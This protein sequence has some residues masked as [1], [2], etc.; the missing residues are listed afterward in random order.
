MKHST[1]RKWLAAI[2]L[3][4]VPFALLAAPL[5]VIPLTVTG[6]TGTEA[7][8]DF[9]VLVRLSN[10]IEGF[11]YDDCKANGEDVTF[12]LEDGTVLSREIDT[13]NTEGESLIW[14]RLPVLERGARFQ[15]WYDDESITE[16]PAS[17]TDGSVWRPSGYIG[18][19]HMSELDARDSTGLGND[20]TLVGK[21]NVSA[22]AIVE[23][24]VGSAQ[25]FDGVSKIDCGTG[26][27]PDM[28]SGVSVEGWAR[29]SDFGDYRG[30]LGKT[31]CFA[32][33]F[34]K[35]KFGL[36]IPN[37]SEHNFSGKLANDQWS[38][39]V[40]TFVPVTKDGA[41]AYQDGVS[42][43]KMDSSFVKVPAKPSR[44]LLGANQWNNQNFKGELDELRIS[45]VIRSADWALGCYETMASP[46]FLAA[47]K[48]LVVEDRTLFVDAV[49]CWVGTT[50]PGYGYHFGLPA[51]TNVNCSAPACYTNEEG[52][53]IG[54]CTG[55]QLTKRDNTVLSSGE[56]NTYSYQQGDSFARLA[57]SFD[58]TCRMTAT[59][60]QGTVTDFDTWVPYGSTQTFT[61]VPDG[62][63]LVFRRWKGDV[64]PGHECENPLQLV[65]EGPV[66]LQADILDEN[67]CRWTGFGTNDL[68]ST[69]ENWETGVVPAPGA[70]I[71]LDW[72]GTDA[73]MTWDLDIPVNSWTQDGYENTVTI[74]T[75]FGSEGFT[76]F[77]ITGDCTLKSGTWTH[78]D[79]S[80]TEEYRLRATI[81]GKMTVGPDARISAD[82]IGFDTGKRPAGLGNAPGSTG[83]AYGGYPGSLQGS[84][85]SQS[86]YG[87]LF[88]PENLGAGGSWIEGAGAIR[89]DI[90]GAFEHNGVVS[91]DSYPYCRNNGNKNHYS[92]SGGSVYIHA[93]SIAGQGTITADSS[94]VN[95]SGSG[96][97]IALVLTDAEADFSAY[98]VVKQ[99]SAHGGDNGG[100]S[101]GASGTIYAETAQDGAG[102]GW[103]VMN[104]NP[105]ESKFPDGTVMEFLPAG[106]VMAFSRITLTN[107]A[108]ASL[109]EGAVLDVASTRLEAADCPGAVNGIRLDGGRIVGSPDRPFVSGG[110]IIVSKSENFKIEAPSI[111][112]SAG[113]FLDIR[114]E[115]VWPK[116]L[117]FGTNSA[118]ILSAPFDVGGDLVFESGAHG[119]GVG[120]FKENPVPF[121]LSVAGDL[122]MEEGSEIEM[123]SRGFERVCG[124]SHGIQQAGGCYGGAPGKSSNNTI[125]IIKPYG[126][127]RNPTDPGSGG[128]ETAGGGVILLDVGGELSLDGAIW[129]RS[130][131]N[132]RFMYYVGSGGSINVTARSIRGKGRIGADGANG[133]NYG[134]GSG[135]RVAVTLTGSDSTF[136]LFTG[137]ITA[138]GSRSDWTPYAGAGTVYLREKGEAIDQGRLIV[139]NGDSPSSTET[140]I[141]TELTDAQVG[142]VVISDKAVLSLQEDAVLFVSGDFT[143]GATFLAG[144]RSVVDFTGTS[145]S[146]ISGDST[147]STLSSSSPGKTIRFAA[148]STQC[149]TGLLSFAGSEAVK[150]VLRST[151]AGVPWKL[152]VSG[153][154][155]VMDVDVADSDASEGLLVTAINSIDGGG[156]SNW[157]F[158]TVVPGETVTWTGDKSS[159]WSDAENWSPGRIP[160][161]TDCVSIPASVPR[162]PELDNSV[163][164][165]GL[166]I[167][168]G[169]SLALCGRNLDVSGETAVHG[170][171]IASG[172]E[173]V[174]LRG[175]VF[176][177]SFEAAN[178]TIVLTGTERQAFQA[179]DVVLF[180]LRD[181][182]AI[183]VDFSSSFT[184]TDFTCIVPAEHELVFSPG[185]CM[186]AG[187]LTLSGDPATAS[188][189][190]SSAI[191][192]RRWKI[193]SSV[194]SIRGVTVRDSDATAGI[195]IYPEN[196]VDGGNNLGWRF[197][198][199]RKRW[200]GSVDG[201]FLNGA[202]WADGQAPSSEDDL[203]IVSETPVTVG[204][205]SAIGG[206]TVGGGTR[207]V[208]DAPLSVANNVVVERNGTL[209]WNKPGVIGGNLVLTAGSTMTHDRN[210][211]TFKNGIDLAVH[212]SG[213]ISSGAVIDVTGKGFGQQKGPGFNGNTG[214]SHGGRG[215][216]GTVDCISC[217]GSIVSPT[218]CGSGGN[219]GD[220]PGGG[221]VILAFDG[222]LALD[223]SILANG[224][225]V[226]PNSSYKGHYNGTGGSINLL[227][228]A[229]TGAGRI[230]AVGGCYDSNGSFSGGGR[231]A[232]KVTGAGSGFSTF[233]GSFAAY[234]GHRPDGSQGAS[235]GTIYTE[236]ASEGAGTGQVL[237]DG[238]P[239]CFVNKAH[240]KTDFPSS[241]L[242]EEGE[243]EKT[244]V[245]VKGAA[246]LNLMAD[247][248]VE[249]IH[250]EGPKPILQLNGHTL[251]VRRKQ[252][253]LGENEATQV[254][255]SDGGQIVWKPHEGPTLLMLR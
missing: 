164:V 177:A 45:K 52:S 152:K 109:P 116:D 182:N 46:S 30:M 5:R 225:G 157:A 1:W 19:W 128:A 199:T 243:T 166:A 25:Y 212:G 77:V 133:V 71:L 251:T 88:A 90:A 42:K 189:R 2:S 252:H 98:D 231:I 172:T 107:G 97:R 194:Y 31:D 132:P 41:R 84:Y 214:S 121:D 16:Q 96:G 51:G 169:G 227:S 79:N 55:W 134:G 99:V 248:M 147:F 13:W 117:T 220:T 21:D 176:L 191:P 104:G 179:P 197:T 184:V 103:L 198:D 86:L 255:Y 100:D 102:H 4:V 35:G 67:I 130:K 34:Y 178:S 187:N 66:S 210:L 159:T 114:D 205:E 206:L 108:V 175:D 126:S 94:K 150:T 180:G 50:V 24:K 124:P 32:P 201:D 89:L 168:T 241:R 9:P 162:Y 181:E 245:V 70:D 85:P 161:K 219:W 136:G 215:G 81:G 113:G 183:G 11:S 6:Y 105:R 247:T 244:T 239:S 208:V 75:R 61:A 185:I 48:S 125:G 151:E 230:E 120:P 224:I 23:G 28:F 43:G 56:E 44:L 3:A 158:S 186:T 54:V 26:S 207:L 203:Y 101:F 53:L 33:R 216:R 171:V 118:M 49:P 246:T 200:T 59:A 29:T 64:P 144:P 195:D 22:N 112:F 73:P 68:A 218:N 154:T 232:V 36:M 226:D 153:A 20:G 146:M 223:G 122:V 240:I 137:S 139:A 254:T 229:L 80:T 17:Q 40:F 145:D 250:L 140:I 163:V 167:E 192:G 82:G 115:S 155:S 165:T 143:N 74:A 110:G 135:G 60:N 39:A 129:S 14:V 69:A 253:A 249:D 47:Q 221:L 92:G 123:D 83:G 141:S 76:N 202:N 37:F 228:S 173:V 63:G 217:Y 127:I 58:V 196:S 156:N 174:T 213:H 204:G 160:L 148:E 237:V 242:C 142:D 93:G 234:G 119:H 95:A 27:N 233:Q 78:K 238:G 18:V 87:N 7:L 15:C 193:N 138:L 12:T 57:W 111:V 72:L 65:V 211:G 188:L 236:V 62:P 91:A 131:L 38:H 190:L 222:P 8:T 235:S 170:L 209:A 10:Q 149:V 106:A